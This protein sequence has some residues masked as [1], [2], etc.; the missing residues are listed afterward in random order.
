LPIVVTAGLFWSWRAAAVLT[1]ASLGVEIMVF[2]LDATG[3]LP[4]P[5]RA[6]TVELLFRIFAG[7]LTMTAV[8]VAV[9]LHSLRGAL[10]DV[11]RHALRTEELLVHVPD[12]LA[13]LDRLGVV[14]A[15]GPAMRT[16]TG[17][18]PKELVGKHVSRVDMFGPGRRS[19]A[20]DLRVLS[21]PDNEG[22]GALELELRCK[23]GGGAWGEARLHTLPLGKGDALRRIVLYDVTG[24]HLAEQRQADLEKRVERGKRLETMGLLVGG[25]THDFNNLLTVILAVGSVL[26]TQ[27]P[28][29]SMASELLRDINTSAARAAELARQLLSVRP[30]EPAEPIDVSAE[31]AALEPLLSRMAGERIKL[32]VRAP[33]TPCIVK[34][35]RAELERIATNLVVNAKDAMPDGGDIVVEIARSLEVDGEGPAIPMVELRVTD[36][37]VGMDS[38]T[39]QRIFEP[40][41]TTKGEAGTGLGLATVDG[42]VSRIG[43]CIRVDSRPGR[44]TNIRVLLPEAGAGEVSS[45]PAACGTRQE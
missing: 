38:L 43:G 21:A 28:P 24:R 12:V 19:L 20:E 27:L 4:V 15:V 34:I 44:G 26:D 9:A 32:V 31:I 39:R 3:R 29:D 7:S 40:F 8:L 33:A 22:P 30:S 25:V 16:R 45:S 37:G 36:S 2:W 23:D 18:E 1:V 35:G 13:V 42:I 5:L 10:Q 11:R 6:P 14:L 41:Y 17:Y